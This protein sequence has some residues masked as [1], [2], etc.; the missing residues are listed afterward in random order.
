CPAQTSPGL[1]ADMVN[2]RRFTILPR[3]AQEKTGT[4]VEKFPEASWFLPPLVGQPVHRLGPKIVRRIGAKSRCPAGLPT[5]PAARQ[6]LLANFS[7]AG[8]IDVPT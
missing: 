4:P 5:H 8:P 6:S 7:F 2:V 1:R 3:F